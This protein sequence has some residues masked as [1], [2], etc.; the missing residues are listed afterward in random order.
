MGIK[1]KKEKGDGKNKRLRRRGE[2]KKG[3]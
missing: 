1:G 3:G 2:D